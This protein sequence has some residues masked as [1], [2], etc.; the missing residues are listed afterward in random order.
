MSKIPGN[1]KIKKTNNHARVIV[2]ACTGMSPLGQLLL[3]LPC[4]VTSPT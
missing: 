2:Y 4:G 1:T 3:I